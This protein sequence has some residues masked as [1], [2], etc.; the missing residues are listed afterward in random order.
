MS[1][2]CITYISEEKICGK[3]VGMNIVA[4]GCHPC[5]HH[6]TGI[7]S[8]DMN[9]FSTGV[10]N[11][12]RRFKTLRKRSL[13]HRTE[14]WR[15]FC[16]VCKCGRHFLPECPVMMKT[17]SDHRLPVGAKTPTGL[18]ASPAN[19]R[20]FILCNHCTK[21]RNISGKMAAMKVVV[22]GRCPCRHRRTWNYLR[23]HESCVE[24][25][26]AGPENPIGSLIGRSE[27]CILCL[28]DTFARPAWDTMRPND[29]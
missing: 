16:K 19:S 23:R 25:A 17:I 10:E 5:R 26:Q 2:L 22:R 27:F 4:S 21:A 12:G 20:S 11:Q 9:C 1:I 6:Q 18:G 3:M 29:K 14:K 24:S 13:P 7:A 8:G 28:W 15:R